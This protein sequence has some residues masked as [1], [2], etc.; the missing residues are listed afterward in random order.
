MGKGVSAFTDSSRV[1]SCLLSPYKEVKEV[2]ILFER[3]EEDPVI[4]ATALATL[5][6]ATIHNVNVLSEELSQ[7]EFDN[8]KLKEEVINLKA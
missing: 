6:Q 5:S 8:L 4:V 7:A 3:I 2:E 1:G